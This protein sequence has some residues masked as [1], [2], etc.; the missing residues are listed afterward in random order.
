MQPIETAV[1]PVHAHPWRAVA[2]L[3]SRRPEQLCPANVRIFG[4]HLPRHSMAEDG[5]RHGIHVLDVRGNRLTV[6]RLS[7]R[8]PITP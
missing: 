8:N 4:W 1:F 6:E 2:Y 7:I 3:W 5:L